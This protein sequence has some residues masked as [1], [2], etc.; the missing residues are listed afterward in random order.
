MRALDARQGGSIPPILTRLYGANGRRN[1]FKTRKALV[2]IQL[3]PQLVYQVYK[4]YPGT[5]KGVP[6]LDL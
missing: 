3:Q 2:R 4:E 1:G 5:S 6:S